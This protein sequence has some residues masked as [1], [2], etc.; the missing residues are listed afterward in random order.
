MFPYLREAVAQVFGKPSTENFPAV[1]PE[2]PEGYRG[3]IVYHP[4]L[5]INCGLCQRVCAP[6]AMTKTIEPTE[7]GDRITMTFNMGSCTFCQLCADFC[8]RH[9]IEMSKDY[10]MVVEDEKDLLVT[11]TFIK[12]KPAPKPKPEAAKPEAPKPEA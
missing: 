8:S 2:A 12:K 7:E 3:R 5:C 10:M 4:E 1:I 9:A 11:G 6:Q